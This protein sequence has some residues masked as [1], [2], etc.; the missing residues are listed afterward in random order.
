MK[1]ALYLYILKCSDDSY[2]TGIT[3][4]MDQRL[5]EHQIGINKSCY[6]Y[7]KRPVQL[8]FSELFQ[9]NLYCIEWEKKIKRWTRRKKE[10]LIE[11][12]YNDLHEFSTC[13][14]QTH[15]RNKIK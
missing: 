15:F 3:N 10:A 8:V 9:D 5:S 1:M 13:K 14:N 11:G 7:N 12:N 2:Y 6:T 4:D